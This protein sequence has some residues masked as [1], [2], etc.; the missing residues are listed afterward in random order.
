MGV[1]RQERFSDLGIGCGTFGLGLVLGVV[2]GPRLGSSHGRGWGADGAFPLCSCGTGCFVFAFVPCPFPLQAKV[3][4]FGSHCGDGIRAWRLL[5]GLGPCEPCVPDV[6]ASGSHANPAGQKS[7]PG[8]R[9][10]Y[11]GAWLWEKR[12]RP[13]CECPLLGE[14][15][16]PTQ[17]LGGAPREPSRCHQLP[18]LACWQHHGCLRRMEGPCARSHPG[19][20]KGQCPAGREATS[21]VTSPP[22]GISR[23]A[24][25][26]PTGFPKDSPFAGSGLPHVPLISDRSGCTAT[27]GEARVLGCGPLSSTEE[28]R[29]SQD[30]QAL[31]LATH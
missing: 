28:E 3:M 2:W 19:L 1:S 6:R 30:P 16:S 21:E 18:S 24:P 8:G 11:R 25:R 12:P 31:S 10:W 22:V 5:E 7:P 23:E 29:P 17:E 26:R 13:L 15:G 4:S 14:A 27:D 20:P 9:W